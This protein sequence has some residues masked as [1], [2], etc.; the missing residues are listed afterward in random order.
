[1]TRSRWL[2]VALALILLPGISRADSDRESFVIEWFAIGLG[3]G[4]AQGNGWKV[5][6]VAGQPVGGKSTASGISLIG[7]F[8]LPGEGDGDDDDDGDIIAYLERQH[9]NVAPQAALTP[10]ME[11]PIVEFSMAPVFPNPSRGMTRIAWAVPIQSHVRI[12]VHDVQGR[13]VASLAD[14]EYSPGRYQVTWNNQRAGG[15]SPGMYFVRL[16]SP[17]RT[18]VRRV[19][20]AH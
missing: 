20:L 2:L 16:Q 15:V 5:D 4:V 11:A 10:S 6:G 1:M 9:A 7:G 13:L 14:G 12:T 19:V 3:G 8:W 18:F 17:E